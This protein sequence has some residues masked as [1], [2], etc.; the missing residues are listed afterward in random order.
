VRAFVAEKGESEVQ[1]G[2][3]DPDAGELGEGDVLVRVE[4]SSVNYK[5]ALATTAKG[6]V[7]KISPLVPGID[8]AGTV[9][10][11]PEGA[12]VSP[13]DSVLAHGYDLGVAHHGGYAESARVPGEWIVALPEGLSAREA[14]TIGTAGYTAARSVIAL[15]NHGLEA[16]DGPV[17]VTGASGGLGSMA[18]AMLAATG[19]HVVASS[20]KEDEEGWLQALGAA[21]VIGREEA[22]GDS[23][24]PLESERWAG[25]VD[26]VGGET[27]AGVLRA[28][29]AGAAVAASGNTGGM[30][31]PTTVLPFILRGVS[32][33]GIDSVNTPIEERTRTWQRLAT[34]LRPPA[35]DDLVSREISLDEVDEALEAILA[36]KLRGRTVVRVSATS[37]E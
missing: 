2:L 22:A 29:R 28:L 30:K 21:E 15:Q 9:E 23:S 35:I 31:V 16:G 1:R 37:P 26:C 13:G 10:E 24:R 11:A 33:I 3:R 32:L 6:G 20:G 34:D 12:S 8:L 27:L 4:Y 19:H 7:A 17:L 5:D 14:M 25:A 36:G 18:V